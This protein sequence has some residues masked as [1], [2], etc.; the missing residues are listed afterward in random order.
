MYYFQ[1]WIYAEA[2]CRC[3]RDISSAFGDLQKN[4]WFAIYERFYGNY[5]QFCYESMA[6]EA[7]GQIYP[8]SSAVAGFRG[9]TDDIKKKVLLGHNWQI[10]VNSLDA[11]SNNPT[12]KS[13]I[14]EI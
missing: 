8:F 12:V 2:S 9:F 10:D 11:D 7:R 13:D 3:L 1:G 14:L 4:D 5:I 6:A